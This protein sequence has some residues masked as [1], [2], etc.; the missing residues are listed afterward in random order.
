[1]ALDHGKFITALYLAQVAADNY[2]CLREDWRLHWNDILNIGSGIYAPYSSDVYIKATAM[3][4]LILGLRNDK[5]E[6]CSPLDLD[7][8]PRVDWNKLFNRNG[9]SKLH[10]I[11]YGM[12]GQSLDA[13]IEARPEDLDRQDNIGLTA[14]WYACWLGNSNHVSILIHYGADVNNASIPPICA[15]VTRGS[16]NLVEQL[17]NAG[18]SITDSWTE[19][20]YRTLMFRRSRPG[21]NVEEILAI[22]KVLFGRFIDTN[23]INPL[24]LATPLIALTWQRSSCSLSRMRQ[25]LELGADTDLCDEYGVSPLH[26]AIFIGNV[27]GCKIL[28]RAGANACVQHE[29]CGTIL[30]MAIRRATHPDIIQAVSELDLSGIELGAKDR[31]G[32]TAFELLKFRAGGPQNGQGIHRNLLY[33]FLTDMVFLRFGDRF[34]KLYDKVC[35]GE[36]I[37]TELKILSL[38]QTLLQQV[39]EAQRVPIEDRYPLLSLTSESLTVDYNEDKPLEPATPIMPGAWPEE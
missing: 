29:V 28:G 18:T 16:Y 35:R 4:Q 5:E 12:T 2:D 24:G 11:V 30:H 23:F 15:A 3:S 21:E 13:E 27:E 7:I 26:H 39:Q 31:S 8:A 32:R 22:D 6:T 34:K 10:K 19:S 33:H 14:L 36:D 38:F 9:F 37:Y 20:L 1:M 25:L 17:L